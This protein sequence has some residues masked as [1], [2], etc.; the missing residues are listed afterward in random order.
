MAF[1]L[2]YGAWPL[3]CG[4][5]IGSSFYRIKETAGPRQIKGSIEDKLRWLMSYAPASLVM[6][7]VEG[8][9]ADKELFCFLKDKGSVSVEEGNYINI[10]YT[11]S[12]FFFNPNSDNM[13]RILTLWK[14]YDEDYIKRVRNDNEEDD[15]DR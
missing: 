15:D 1:T 2:N 13:C 9:V 7:D 11:L 14:E 10:H 6:A 5:N 3:F 4:G 8:G 12:P